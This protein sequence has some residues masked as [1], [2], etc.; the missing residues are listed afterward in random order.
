MQLVNVSQP[1]SARAPLSART[2]GSPD[3]KALGAQG[4][5]SARRR[6]SQ[7]MEIFAEAAQKLLQPDHIRMG[8]KD[9]K[10]LME[11][12]ESWHKGGAVKFDVGGGG[13]HGT[14]LAIGRK[15]G[16]VPVGAD[17]G[18]AV[19]KEKTG[20][21]SNMLEMR[22]AARDAKQ[23][24]MD[25]N[26]LSPEDRELHSVLEL[27]GQKA[28]TKYR[29]V[30]QALRFV[31]SDRDGYI[32]KSEIYYFFRAYDVS[33]DTAAERL[34]TV[35]DRH[36]TGEVEY[37]AF[38][39]YLG[40]FIRG[41][42]PRQPHA[43]DS[44]N[45]E[46]TT[47]DGESTAQA[48]VE[49]EK[50]QAAT[51]SPHAVASKRGVNNGNNSKQPVAPPTRQ[52]DWSTNEWMAFLGRKCSERFTHVMDLIRKV[53]QD[54][55]GNISR[56]EMR[57]FFSIF[58]LNARVSDRC[59]MSLKQDEDP[60]V[61]YMDFMRAIAP[62]VDLPGVNAVL[63]QGE[64]SGSKRIAVKHRRGMC[65]ALVSSDIPG[66]QSDEQL[67]A[68]ERRRKVRQLQLMM[69]DIG[70]KL[71]TKFRHSRDAF[72]GLDLDK[73]GSISP[74]ELESF[75]RGFG[76]DAESAQSLFEL[77][78]EECNGEID[79]ALFMSHF[80]TVVM[81][82]GS[83]AKRTRHEPLQDQDL[84]KE[85]S[86]IARIV[87]VNLGTKYTKVTD[88][89]RT[90]DL[91]GD[92]CIQIEEMRNFFRNINLPIDKAD[93]LFYCLDSEQ[94]GMVSFKDFMALMCPMIDPGKASTRKS[95]DDQDGKPNRPQMWRLQ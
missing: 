6:S 41:E 14:G 2:N 71:Q 36:R 48:T 51:E 47:A 24:K 61:D 53:D 12:K 7:G 28:A 72:R 31:D 73:D 74:S 90:L 8:S 32:Q 59:F 27:V 80:S 10:K 52:D 92:G 29:N 21:L 58:G 44:D 86:E 39:D 55:D 63:H 17:G 22:G 33:S 87:G 82:G 13:A 42:P 93:K 68:L 9:S 88:A 37:K 94:S 60:E 23:H 70:R 30:R 3:K 34:F 75:L 84:N 66:L 69:Q 35:L 91:S 54:Y 89:F 56:S 43:E 49:V 11:S 20:K 16:L 65:P 79:F 26:W 78:D 46:S 67:A 5:G 40:P 45:E 18:G 19:R 81:P 25:N 95:L 38:V 77:L 1:M 57:H 62:Y 85:I 15:I 50:A 4:P 76:Y 64:G 83:I